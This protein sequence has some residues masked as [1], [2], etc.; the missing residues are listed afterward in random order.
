MVSADEM[1]AGIGIR[2]DCHRD[3]H[4]DVAAG[5]IVVIWLS[6]PELH[7][8]IQLH[9]RNFS[10]ASLDV[11]WRHTYSSSHSPTSAVVRSTPWLVI[12]SPYFWI[13]AT[14]APSGAWWMTTIFLQSSLLTPRYRG[15]IPNSTCR[16]APRSLSKLLPHSLNG[17]IDLESDHRSDC[18]DQKRHC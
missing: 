10:A 17:H 1:D 6:K 8:T 4:G 15:L 9:C 14:A 2:N 12:H 18:H 3:L 16:S 5:A 13:K 11:N 7:Q